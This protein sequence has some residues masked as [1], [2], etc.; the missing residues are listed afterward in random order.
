[1]ATNSTIDDDKA[2]F[3]ELVKWCNTN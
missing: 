1:V 3:I 2:L